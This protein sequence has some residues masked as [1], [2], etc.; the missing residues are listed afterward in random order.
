MCWFISCCTQEMLSTP[1]ATKTSPSPAMM[2]CEAIAMVCRPLLQKRLTV[3]PLT[4]TGRPAR[5]AI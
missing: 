2:R 4:V 3:A 5:S 1:P